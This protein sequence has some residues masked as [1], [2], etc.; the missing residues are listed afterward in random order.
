MI[1]YTELSAAS[2]AVFLDGK[3]VGTIRHTRDDRGTGWAYWP[4]GTLTSG[5][6]YPSLARCK[7]SLSGGD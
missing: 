3:R 6:L 2:V 1:T 5:D 4:K 7:A